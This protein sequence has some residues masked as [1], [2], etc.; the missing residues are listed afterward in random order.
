MSITNQNKKVLQW[1][2]D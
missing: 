1:S 2:L